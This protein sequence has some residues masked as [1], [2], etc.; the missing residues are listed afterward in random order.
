MVGVLD[1]LC[2]IDVRILDRVGDLT[3]F[4]LVLSELLRMAQADLL[5]LL[6]LDVVVTDA[7]S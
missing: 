4:A 6:L 7:T 2:D 1:G 3:R 5:L